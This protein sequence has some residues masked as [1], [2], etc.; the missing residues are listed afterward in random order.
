[1]KVNNW[2]MFWEIQEQL[3]LAVEELQS[4][5]YGKDARHDFLNGQAEVVKVI[6]KNIRAINCEYDARVMLDFCAEA[7]R[8]IGEQQ[9]SN[10]A[11]ATYFSFDGSVNIGRKE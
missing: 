1:M 7:I 10:S 6:L 8:K 9:Y 2:G 5:L 3:L 11:P 4:N